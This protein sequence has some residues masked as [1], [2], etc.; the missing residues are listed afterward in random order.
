[1]ERCPQCGN[2]RYICMND[3]SD[4]TFAANDQVC[5]AKK[6]QTKHEKAKEKSD[7]DGI[8]VSIEPYTMSGT[9]LLL[10]RGP[11][12]DKKTAERDQ[13]A[14]SRVII[15]RDAPPGATPGKA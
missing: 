9:D 3:D 14:K 2:P 7:R 11:F 8:V 4:I 13:V 12:Y 6:R 1:M 15:P 5:Y 10:F